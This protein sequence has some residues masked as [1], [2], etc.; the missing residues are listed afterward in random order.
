MTDD[1]KGPLNAL[2]RDAL[3]GNSFPMIIDAD[4]VA[5]ILGCSREH[6]N[7]L[8]D[9]GKLPAVKYGRHWRFVTAQ[10]IYHMMADAERNMC[11]ADALVS[12]R[13]PALPAADPEPKPDLQ[14]S[15]STLVIEPSALPKRRGRPCKP[16][17][18]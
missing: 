1:K 6:V 3:V 10:V 13:D 17:P 5:D 12:A 16:V 8:A 11:D 15:G 7:T 14:S 18:D 2:L 9:A 4:K